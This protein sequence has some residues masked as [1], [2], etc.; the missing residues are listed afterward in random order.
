M[1]DQERGNQQTTQPGTTCALDRQQQ[2][3]DPGAFIGQADQQRTRNVRAQS[4]TGSHQ[5]ATQLTG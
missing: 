4:G 2:Q 5:A 1:R 3:T